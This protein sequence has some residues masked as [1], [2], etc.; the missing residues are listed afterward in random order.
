MLRPI[1]D[2]PADHMALLGFDTMAICSILSLIIGFFAGEWSFYVLSFVFLFS[3]WF[4]LR[5]LCSKYTKVYEIMSAMISA[6][7][8]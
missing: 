2:N 3:S 7:R 6:Y 4:G 8:D 1:P 5:D